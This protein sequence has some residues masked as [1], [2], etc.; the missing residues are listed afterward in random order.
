[1]K[2][3]TLIECGHIADA[4]YE[5]DTE[6][7][8][9]VDEDV[10]RRLRQEGRGR[11]AEAAMDNIW[12][13]FSNVCRG[14]DGE[15]YAVETCMIGDEF[16]PVCWAPL[17]KILPAW[18]RLRQLRAAAGLTQKALAAAAGINIRQIQKLEAGEIRPGN[19]TLANAVRLAN[20]LGIRPEALLR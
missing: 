11:M 19:L 6:K 15:L 1:M 3:E 17:R 12:D 10:V 9:T 7:R 8:Y 20:A 5:I 4:G 13:G 2:F 18:E 14:E 16:V